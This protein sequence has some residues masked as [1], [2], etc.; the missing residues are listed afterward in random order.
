MSKMDLK[1][2]LSEQNAF[3]ESVTCKFIVFTASKIIISS[4]SYHKQNP[5]VSKVSKDKFIYS[6]FCHEYNSLTTKITIRQFTN[7]R[8]C[9]KFP[10]QQTLPQYKI[11]SQQKLLQSQFIYRK[12]CHK[13]NSSTAK[14]A[15]NKIHLQQNLP[16]TK[17]IYNKSCCNQNLFLANIHF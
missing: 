13:R 11:R 4:K 7:G 12:R 5:F 17:F 16:Q 3:T 14:V 10:Q 15:T 8:I 9:D 1:Q 6:K 2:R